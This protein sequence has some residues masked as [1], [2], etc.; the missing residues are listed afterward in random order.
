[1]K[2]ARM[3]FVSMTLALACGAFQSHVLAESLVH[4]A[5]SEVTIPTDAQINRMEQRAITTPPLD[6]DDG[7]L[8]GGQAAQIRQMDQRAHRIDEK[9]LKDDGVCDGC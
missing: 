9:L 2:T 1:M 8:Q 4:M 3:L 7:T 5:Q 6:V